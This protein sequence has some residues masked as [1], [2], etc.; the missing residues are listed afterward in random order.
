MI[1]PRRP[2][3]RADAG[4]LLVGRGFGTRVA[5]T[6]GRQ[7][8]I[9]DAETLRCVPG[10][11][12]GAQPRP[13]GLARSGTMCPLSLT[14]RPWREAPESPEPPFAPALP[15]CGMAITSLL[16]VAAWTRR[17]NHFRLRRNKA[18]RHVAPAGG[19][20]A[21]RGATSDDTRRGPDDAPLPTEGGSSGPPAPESRWRR[22]VPARGPRRRVHLTMAAG[23][24]R[25]GTPQ[26][27]RGVDWAQPA[28][29]WRA[30]RT[31]RAE[32]A[33]PHVEPRDAWDTCRA[34]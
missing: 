33:R 19:A 31:G 32:L 25:S 3:A 27:P 28:A 20:A 9:A 5:T 4:A 26:R 10:S 29:C 2:P 13:V 24:S 18:R 15:P 8:G 14:T 30:H 11:P 21:G 7:R 12:P 6:R 17:A 23:R 16:E 1:R 34:T 22:L